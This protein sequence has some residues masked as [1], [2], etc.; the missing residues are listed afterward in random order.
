MDVHVQAE[1]D[2]LSAWKKQKRWIGGHARHAYFLGLL[3]QKFSP[4]AGILAM[5][6]QTFFLKL[7]AVQARS[8]ER[9]VIDYGVHHPSNTPDPFSRIPH[10]SPL[11]YMS[12]LRPTLIPIDISRILF[13]LRVSR[14]SNRWF[15]SPS[16]HR[17][18]VWNSR[19][20]ARTTLVSIPEARHIRNGSII[21][22]ICT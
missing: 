5:V 3:G 14:T 9:I 18:I 20:N 19:C 4:K 13:L 7:I 22:D 16:S 6:S 12:S 21:I 11:L 10:T 17:S 15:S 1:E 8:I 2:A